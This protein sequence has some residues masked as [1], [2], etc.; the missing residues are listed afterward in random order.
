[1]SR[2]PYNRIHIVGASGA[3]VTTLGRGL[4]ARFAIPHHDTDDYFWLPT[5]PP[6]RDIRPAEDRL[7]L[8]KEMFLARPTWVLSGSLTGWG[9][10]LIELFDTVVFIT[11]PAG[12][13][14]E[15]LK[16]RELERYGEPTEE[17]RQKTKKFLEWAASYD[18]GDES[19]RSLACHTK[20]L[21]NIKAPVIRVDG[22]EAPQL[23]VQ[24]VC[25]QMM[26]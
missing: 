24:K 15:R 25:R 2:Q 23:M 3:G 4:A 21:S 12:V 9:D 20:W 8:M 10:P 7:R 13:R 22:S 18:E 1:V 5:N 16:G 26:K 17:E 19:M 6:Y 11:T 14:L